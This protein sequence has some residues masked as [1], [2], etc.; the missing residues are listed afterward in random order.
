MRIKAN[1]KL[2]EIAGEKMVV[3]N[4]TAGADLT[5]VVMLNK[6]A[7]F[8][9]NCLQDKEFCE[10]DVIGI[11][12]QEYKIDKKQADKDAVKWIESMEKV[13]LIES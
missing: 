10:N 8:L 6:S 4:G 12:M 2:R 1:Q 3:M 13:G 5:K 7:E 9:W 11:L